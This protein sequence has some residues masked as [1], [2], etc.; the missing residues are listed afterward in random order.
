[1]RLALRAIA[2]SGDID[3]DGRPDQAVLGRRDGKVFVGVVVSSKSR[4]EIL[5]FAVGASIHDAICAEPAAL[6]VESLNYTPKKS[7]GRI[8]GFRRST[9]CEGLRLAAAQ[10]ESIHV[11]WNHKIDELDWWR[12]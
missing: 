7:A 3:C 6:Q 8:E 12:P 5:G 11:F 1:M 2:L 4:P 10:C 9:R